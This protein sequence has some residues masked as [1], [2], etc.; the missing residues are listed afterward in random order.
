MKV[1]NRNIEFEF[2]YR[3]KNNYHI[4]IGR[5]CTYN[6]HEKFQSESLENLRNEFD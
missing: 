2:Y 3:I 4:K 5:K 6:F 1:S